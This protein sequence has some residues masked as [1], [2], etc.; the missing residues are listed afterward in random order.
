LLATGETEE[1][2]QHA[3]FGY[4]KFKKWGHFLLGEAA[5]VVGQ[6]LVAQGKRDEALTYLHEARSD[7]QRLE[8][9][10]HLSAWEAFMQEHGLETASG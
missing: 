6:I 4:E 2:L 10:H 1:A 5:F 7:W 8:L 9:T 3:M